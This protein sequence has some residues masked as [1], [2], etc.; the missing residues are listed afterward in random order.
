MS[1]ITTTPPR[2][3]G[4]PGAGGPLPLS[5]RHLDDLGAS[6]LAD[7]T[8]RAAGLYTEADAGAVSRLLGWDRPAASLGDCLVFPYPGL[9]NYARVKPDNPRSA[10]AK[11][12][13]YESPRGRPN[14]AYVP[15]GRTRDALADPAQ[16]L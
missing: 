13:K 12:V 9:G 10:G 11:P 7:D 5:T 2:L 4:G 3:Q 8:I 15:P 6:G 16:R 1:E 14:R